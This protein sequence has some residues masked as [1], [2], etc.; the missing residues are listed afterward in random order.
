[1]QGIV[2]RKLQCKHNRKD[3]AMEFSQTNNSVKSPGKTLQRES[4]PTG[5][6]K[7]IS[8]SWKVGVVAGGDGGRISVDDIKR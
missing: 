6:R 3:H 7:L 2:T 4:K 5:P 1:M 8:L